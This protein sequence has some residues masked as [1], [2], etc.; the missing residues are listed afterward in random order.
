MCMLFRLSAQR[1][2]NTYL[3]FCF[4][5]VCLLIFGVLS[6]SSMKYSSDIFSLNFSLFLRVLY[7]YNRFSYFLMTIFPKWLL[8]VC[9]SDTSCVYACAYEKKS[10]N[11]L[12]RVL[13]F[14]TSRTVF[15]YAKNGI[16]HLDVCLS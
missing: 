1:K 11:R 16:W 6:F 8:D 15:I 5:N 2:D 14:D 13:V 9:L 10:Q 12:R 7:F 3:Q 4:T